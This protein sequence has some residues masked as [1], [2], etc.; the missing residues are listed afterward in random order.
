MFYKWRLSY[1][2]REGR[3]WGTGGLTSR[4]FDW[5]LLS[6]ASLLLANMH[7]M[8]V[9]SNPRTAKPTLIEISF[10]RISEKNKENTNNMSVF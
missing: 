3:G 9:M 5:R 6:S 2:V 8:H 10:N 1:F 7:V 4:D